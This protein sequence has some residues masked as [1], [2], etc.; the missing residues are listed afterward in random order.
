M[1]VT[2]TM[3][4]QAVQ[5]SCDPPGILSAPVAFFCISNVERGKGG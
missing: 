1:V 2:F 4:L 5:S 3:Q